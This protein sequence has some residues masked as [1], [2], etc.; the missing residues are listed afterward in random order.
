M[1]VNGRTD[2]EN[3]IHT[4]TGMLLSYKEK[5]NQEVFKEIDGSGK[6]SVN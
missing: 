3:V 5:G 1:P 6:H 2:N 4:D